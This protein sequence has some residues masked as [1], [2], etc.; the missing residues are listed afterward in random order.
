MRWVERLLSL[1]LAAILLVACSRPVATP[2]ASS[3]TPAPPPVD[4]VKP[5]PMRKEPVSVQVEYR[6]G[7]A[8][9][10][11]TAL[12]SHVPPGS[13]ELRLTFSKPVRRQEVEQALAQ[14]QGAP[15]RGLMQWQNDQTLIWSVAQLPP[16]IDFLLGGAH[17]QEGQSLPGS[18][19]SLRVGDPPVLAEVDLSTAKEEY[20]SV[21]PPDI[22]AVSL[23][24]NRQ[25][26]N[27]VAWTPGASRW[28]WRA[29]EWYLDVRS[30]RVEPG[31]QDGVQARLS[32][33]LDSWVLN[34][35]GTLLA[36][37]RTGSKKGA[38]DLVIMDARGGREQSFPG[39]ALR[40][41]A[42]SAATPVLAWSSDGTQV[43]VVS[44]AQDGSGGE[45]AVLTVLT[46][47]RSVLATG[48]PVSAGVRLGWSAD[49]AR[50]LAGNLLIDLAQ[51]DHTRLPGEA[52]KA[53]GE[54]EPE[55][56]R[57]L[58]SE[59]DWGEVT[60][61][62]PATGMGTPLGAGLLAGWTGPGRVA[63]VR[64]PASQTR[65]VPVGQ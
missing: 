2:P 27:I 63:L 38:L 54:W 8:W 9:L 44:D 13:A 11:V 19:Y 36:G 32:G 26:L 45:L 48:L 59:S 58:Y 10:P 61:F 24:P 62:D 34:P 5:P 43:A 53:R 31:R 40:L 47:E 51:G 12:D 29:T 37:L 35:R 65:Y 30:G 1:G 52:Y 25:F 21:L 33:N 64:W 7:D 49:G 28:D 3:D 55:G 23:S 15:I 46:G 4:T 14:A 17:D 56:S 22:I 16:R 41:G 18:L 6:Y 39:F 60:L 50:L 42:A 57:L 20:R